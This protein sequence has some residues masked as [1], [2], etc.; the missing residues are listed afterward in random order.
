MVL[1]LILHCDDIKGKEKRPWSNV[2]WTWNIGEWWRAAV[3][4]LKPTS[5]CEMHWLCGH[6]M[7]RDSFQDLPFQLLLSCVFQEKRFYFSGFMLFITKN[8]YWNI[9]LTATIFQ[10]KDYGKYF[11]LQYLQQFLILLNIL[12]ILMKKHLNSFV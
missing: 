1:E 8:K 7:R 11:S 3:K 4:M 2:G 10:E 9:L 5:S 6:Q 12:F